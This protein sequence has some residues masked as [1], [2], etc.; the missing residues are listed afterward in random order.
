MIKGFF[1]KVSKSSQAEARLAKASGILLFTHIGRIHNKILNALANLASAWE[2]LDTFPKKPFIVSS[3]SAPCYSKF[4][5]NQVEE[6]ERP[7]FYD[8]KEFMEKGIFSEDASP[9]DRMTVRKMAK[10]YVLIGDVLYRRSWDGLLLRCVSTKEGNDLMEKIYAGVCGTHLSGKSLARKILRQGYFWISMERD[11]IVFVRKCLECQMHGDLSHIPVSELHPT[12]NSWPFSAWGIDII[13]KIY[14]PASNGHEF[15]VVAVDYFSRWIEAQSFK[16]LGAKQMASFIE[17][18]IFCRFGI[19]HHIVSD[20]GVQFQGEVEELLRRY[21]VEH[22]KSS[23]YRPQ[24]N[25]AVEAANKEVKRILKKM[26]QTYRDWAAKLPFA[27]WGHRTTTKSVN[28]ASPFEL[29]YGM[30]AVLPVDLEKQTFKVWVESGMSEPV[31]VK[32]RYEDLVFLDGKRLDARFQDQMRKRRMAR[33]YNKRVD[34]RALKPGDL[35]FKQMKPGIM[36][37]GGKFKPNW[38]GPFVVKKVFARGGVQLSDLEGNEFA[39]L[40]NIDR[41]KRF[42]V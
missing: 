4:Y 25:G 15:I 30:E 11:C 8:L 36:H 39:Q 22:H 12:A 42:F 20:N 26:T 5:V 23:P 16:K 2:D 34:P 13:G 27:L 19:P 1:G 41:L 10:N 18:S 21:K 6:D 35:V 24:T 9:V 17:K 40:I 3:G 37:P 28:G 38:E 33:Y 31:W 29:M 14:P 7:W 32:K